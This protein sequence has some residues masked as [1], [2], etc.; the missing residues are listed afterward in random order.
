MDFRLGSGNTQNSVGFPV[1]Q[2]HAMSRLPWGANRSIPWQ[3]DGSSMVLSSTAS[4]AFRA[5]MRTKW[6]RFRNPRRVATAP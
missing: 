2:S 3:I 5:G 1:S 6:T 4:A